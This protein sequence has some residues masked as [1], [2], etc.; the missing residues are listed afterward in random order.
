MNFRIAHWLVM[1][2]F[3]ALVLTGFALK[4][5]ESWWAPLIHHRGG[6]HRIAAIVLCVSLLYHV[7]HLMLVKRDRVV[8][9]RLLPVFQDALDAL[10]IVR[11]NLGL[12]PAR[13][14][15]R[16]FSYAEKMEYWAFMWGT[17]VMA[18]SG[19]LL[20][21]NNLTLRWF[22]KWL[23]DAATALHFYEAIL[24]TGAIIVWHFYMVI[25]DPEVY[26][27]D[28][29]W[30]TGKAPHERLKEPIDPPKPPAKADENR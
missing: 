10:G 19:F 11:Y 5:P 30:L 17:L 26:P 9:K 18:A 4:F 14:Q 2:S 13:P 7:V 21:F 23:T 1:L 29:A 27:M 20:W 25:F 3:P 12:Q 8:L 16:T 6:V 22:P 28:R 24:A 15:I